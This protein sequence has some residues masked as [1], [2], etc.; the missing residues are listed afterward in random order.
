MDLFVADGLVWVGPEYNIGRDL[1]TGKEL[2]RSIDL[3]ELRTA[4]HHI[5][6]RPSA[7]KVPFAASN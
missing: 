7:A 6:A 4:G 1:K 3:G 5:H 2:R